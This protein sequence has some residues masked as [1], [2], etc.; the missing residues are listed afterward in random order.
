M[1]LT[2]EG[3]RA[4]AARRPRS[5]IPTLDPFAIASNYLFRSLAGR[6]RDRADP[7]RLVYEAQKAKVRLTRLA[8]AIERM[9]GTRPGQRF[10]VQFT[11]TERLE[12]TI[13]NAARRVSVGIVAGTL[14][15]AM[16]VTADSQVIGSWLPI[17]LGVAGA[18]LGIGLIV[19]ILRGNR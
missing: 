17:A 10:Q 14:I 9:A 3:A 13:R 6:F 11:G 19:D 8:E 18:I 5:S 12:V 4:D 7:R 1:A 16:G 2:G 15:I